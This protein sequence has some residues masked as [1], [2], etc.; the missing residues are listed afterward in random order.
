MPLSAEDITKIS[1]AVSGH[2]LPILRAE[3]NPG[4]VPSVDEQDDHTVIENPID[5]ALNKREAE[6]IMALP[7]GTV[8]TTSRN[9]S[10]STENRTATSLNAI[11]EMRKSRKLSRTQSFSR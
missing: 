1:Q 5:L 7:Q 2:V 8:T 9:G 4:S 3:L 10:T 6:L 11:W